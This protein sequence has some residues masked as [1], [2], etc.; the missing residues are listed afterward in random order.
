MAG[1]AEREAIKQRA[2][3][4]L[5]ESRHAL[6]GEVA[7]VSVLWHPRQFL[8]ASVR[9]HRVAYLIGATFAGFVALRLLMVPRSQKVRGRLAGMV[10]AALWPM[11]RGPAI[12]FATRYL[13]SYLP[14]FFPPPP[15]P[16]GTE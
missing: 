7:R 15:T 10:G 1:S 3:R 2:L 14:Q 8:M 4:T 9:K 13:S 16:E 11:L 6:T 12:E 5:Q